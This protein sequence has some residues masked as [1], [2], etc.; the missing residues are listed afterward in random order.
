MNIAT[1]QLFE[2]ALRLADDALILGQRL[3]EWCSNG[4]FL[5]EDIAL[6]NVALDH[7]GRARLFYDC[8]TRFDPQGRSEDTL[9]FLREEREYHNLLLFELPRGDFAFTIVRQF[10]NDLFMVPYLEQLR[11]SRNAPLAAVAG[12]CFKESCYH[13]RRSKYW[14]V[15]LGDGTA[16]SHRRMQEALNTLWGY[17]HELFLMDSLESTLATCGVA[18]DRGALRPGWDRQVDAILREA[19]LERPGAAAWAASG[20]REGQHT[21]YLGHILTEL[22]YMQRTWPGLHW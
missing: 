16:E 11:T 18:V 17:T 3:T 2:Y 5:E 7:I 1:E 8:A 19:T 15:R 14:M 21:E 9:A 4:P 13:L 22:Q 20:G 10:L 6:S 12:K